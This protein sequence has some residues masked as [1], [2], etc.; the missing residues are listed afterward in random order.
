MWTLSYHL[1]QQAPW[2]LHLS[3]SQLYLLTRTPTVCT[4]SQSSYSMRHQHHKSDMF[5]IV[6]VKYVAITR[7]LLS[8]YNYN[9]VLTWAIPLCQ[10]FPVGRLSTCLFPW[11][12]WA[13]VFVKRNGWI[14][15]NFMQALNLLF[16]MKAS[17][18]TLHPILHSI[19]FH[20]ACINNAAHNPVLGTLMLAAP[21]PA[22]HWPN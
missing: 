21:W 20:W 4:Q 9:K 16:Q 22:N 12:L 1:D 17:T 7:L 3:L 2:H 11:V 18:S 13:R 8:L 14:F 6:W 5:K 10:L 15:V 19:R